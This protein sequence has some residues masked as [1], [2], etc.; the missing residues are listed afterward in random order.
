MKWIKATDFAEKYN[1][2]ISNVYVNIHANKKAQWHKKEK[3]TVFIDEEYFLT[4]QNNYIKAKNEASDL[5][6][7]LTDKEGFNMSRNQLSLWLETRSKI[8]SASWNMF[9]S[10][11]TIFSIS[12]YGIMN[13]MYSKTVVEFR[14]LAEIKVFELVQDGQHYPTDDV[15]IEICQEYLME[16]VA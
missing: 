8:S 2:T 4:L 7:L 16:A 3:H 10:D 15:F 12:S 1:M 6:Y 11:N 14:K 13:Q 9:F 5:F